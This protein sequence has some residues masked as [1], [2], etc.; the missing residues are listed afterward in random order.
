MLG[1][2]WHSVTSFLEIYNFR[3]SMS[4]KRVN[5]RLSLPAVQELSL[6]EGMK[7]L[8]PEPPTSPSPAAFSTTTQNFSY[9]SQLPFTDNSVAHANTVEFSFPREKILPTHQ[10]SLL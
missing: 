8:K 5:K 10:L 6:S 3:I 7:Y 2:S 1:K 4:L 9:I